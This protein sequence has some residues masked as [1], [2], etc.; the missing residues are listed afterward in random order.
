MQAIDRKWGRRGVWLRMLAT[1]RFRVSGELKM[2]H[3]H[4]TSSEE[5]CMAE[6][7]GALEFL[8]ICGAENVM[9][10]QN[11]FKRNHFVHLEE[12]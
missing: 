5:G 1:L 9:R 12:C 4:E 7:V 6:S 8:C 3:K 2:L 11:E 10:T